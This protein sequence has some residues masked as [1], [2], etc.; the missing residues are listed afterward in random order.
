ML[1]LINEKIYRI[2]IFPFIL[3]LYGK[4][5][6]PI[7]SRIQFSLIKYNVYKIYMM[8]G[9]KLSETVTQMVKLMV[10]IILR[11]YTNER[12]HIVSVYKN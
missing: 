9:L 5:K 4:R 12:V 3:F 10:I 8:I 1:S 11:P 7:H 2:N 6:Y